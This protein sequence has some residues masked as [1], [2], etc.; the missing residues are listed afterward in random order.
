MRVCI[1]LLFTLI[2]FS[3]TGFAQNSLLYSG[4]M[5]GY[6]DKDQVSIWLQTKEPAQVRLKYWP[7]GEENNYQSSLD[8]VSN[9]AGGNTCRIDLHH[10]KAGKRYRYEVYINSIRQELEVPLYFQTQPDSAFEGEFSF[11]TGSCAYTKESGSIS[12]EDKSTY[13]IYTA[14]AA[15]KPDFMLWLGDNVYFE[16]ADVTTRAGMLHRYSH[17]RGNPYLQH[18]LR[19]AHHFAIW[20]D[21]DFGPNDADSSFVNK[22]YSYEMFRSFW[23]N[24][25]QKAFCKDKSIAH[26]FSWKD[27]DFF[28]LDDRTYRAPARYS[29]A[30]KQLLGKEQINWLISE[31]KNSKATFKFIAMGGQVLNPDKVSENYS[32]YKK[33][34]HYLLTQ[35]EQC[36]VGGI[37]LLTGDRHFSEVSMLRRKNNYPLYEVTCSPL[38]S[39]VQEKKYGRNKLRVTGSL[40]TE[41]N[42]SIVS[43][44][45]KGEGRYVTITLYNNSGKPLW[46][47]KI[48]KSEVYSDH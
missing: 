22:A 16:N 41:R 23:C 30:N 27:A 15:L 18:L 43:V 26:Q 8:A 48:L 10:L 25:D 21:H 37:I 29:R 46:E 40:I 13:Q 14:I 36:K 35:L 2:A 39:S 28:L 6:S 17:S 34:Y 5:P 7:D 9:P 12:E 47:K 38:T 24:N 45:G 3:L 1:L 44:G 31:L 11:A 32:R 4:P 42:F 19:S 20:D 33:E